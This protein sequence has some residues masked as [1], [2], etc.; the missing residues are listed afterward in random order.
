MNRSLMTSLLSAGL[1]A[2]LV[3]ALAPA[4]P[5]GDWLQFRGNDQRNVAADAA[6][7]VEWNKNHIAWKAELPGKAASGPIVAKGR[8]IVTSASGYRHDRLHVAAF[9]VN[10][11]RKLWHRQFWATGR[12]QTNEFSSVAANT[13]ASDGERI[14]AFFS[15]NDLVCLDLDGGLIWYRGI[16]HDYPTAANDVGMS[17]SPV[18]VDNA[19]VVQ[20]EN[21]VNS[22]TI[23]INNQTKAKL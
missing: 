3:A 6:L 19:V 4:A 10:D 18:V 12:T 14:Y 21:E 23:E 8:V 20:V 17:S 9:A 2:A 7:P 16:T 15:S 22:M 1:G 5:A 11:G 13:P